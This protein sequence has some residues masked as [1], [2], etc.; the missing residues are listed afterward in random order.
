MPRISIITAVLPSHADFLDQAA[1]SVEE[2]AAELFARHAWNWQLEW[3]V[4]VDGPGALDVPVLTEVPSITQRSSSREGATAARNRA[5]AVARGDWIFQLDGDDELRPAAFADLVD[6]VAETT[7]AGGTYEDCTWFAGQN[8]DRD[9]V[10]RPPNAN[11]PD[12]TVYDAGAL[13]SPWEA[14]E[15]FFT[16]NILVRRDVV[17][18]CGGW[19]SARAFESRHLLLTV[20]QTERGVATPYG[21]LHYRRWD[22]QT[23]ADP[24]VARLTVIQN[25][26]LC[27]VLNARRRPGDDPV[28]IPTMPATVL[29]ALRS[30]YAMAAD[31]AGTGDDT[32]PRTNP[33]SSSGNVS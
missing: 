16:S 14:I 5:L 4:V 7:G 21:T 3:V 28:S 31:H 13:I 18:R 32:G 17:L 30:Q 10:P 29:A 1:K 25:E 33:G 24:A 19:P 27:A 6:L 26:F 9:G 23:I 2:T 22:G 8:T 11:S 15:P 20:N 12:I